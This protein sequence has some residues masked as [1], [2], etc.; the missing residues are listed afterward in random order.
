M[1]APGPLFGAASPVVRWNDQVAEQG[2]RTS[3]VQKVAQNVAQPM[4]C[5]KLKRNFFSE[6]AAQNIG[7]FLQ[8]PKIA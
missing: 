8:L 6:Y 5:Q 2:D 7:L 4:F 1:L 3:F